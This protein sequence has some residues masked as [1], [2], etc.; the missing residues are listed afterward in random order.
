M[1][2]RL[3]AGLLWTLSAM[4]V[5]AVLLRL[6]NRSPE[7]FARTYWAGIRRILGIR[8]RVQGALSG[9]RPVLFVANHCSWLDIVTLGSVLPGCF[10]AKGEVAKWPLIGLIAK[11]G[12]TI[13]VSRNRAGVG[14]ERNELQDRLAA[15]DNIILF[16]EGTTSDGTR[17]LPFSTAFL[18]LAE[19]KDAP[20]VQPVTL[21]YDA[22]DGLPVRRR[23]RPQ[24]SWYGDMTLAPH[25]AVIGRRRSLHATII[26]HEPVAPGTYSNRKALSAALEA[27]LS[28]Q[29]GKLRQGRD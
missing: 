11:L 14:R 7:R 26:L 17:I 8:V 27:T 19:G 10:I 16:P 4:P 15:G 29:A 23:D 21:V 6:K 9:Q 28:A 24:I 12:R 20:W 25:F 18:A 3:L 22:I 2:L 1:A 5:Q 13:F